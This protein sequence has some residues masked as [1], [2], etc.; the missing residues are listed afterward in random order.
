MSEAF[1]NVYPTERLLKI[2][3]VADR[4]GLSKATIH[5]LRRKKLFPSPVRTVGARVAW[6]ET[7]VMAW[8]AARPRA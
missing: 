3:D 6:K 1:P 8:I 7:E 2:D 4:V 5:R